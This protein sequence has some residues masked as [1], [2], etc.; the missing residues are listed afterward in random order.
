MFTVFPLKLSS[1]PIHWYHN[2]IRSLSIPSDILQHHNSGQLWERNRWKVRLLLLRY[3]WCTYDI[4]ME[5]FNLKVD[6]PPSLNFISSKKDLNVSKCI[7]INKGVGRLGRGRDTSRVAAG[8]H[9][10]VKSTLS[11][12]FMGVQGLKP[13]EATSFWT[14]LWHKPCFFWVILPEYCQILGV[15]NSCPPLQI[16]GGAPLD[17]P[18]P[19]PMIKKNHWST[20]HFEVA[21]CN[22]GVNSSPSRWHTD[23]CICKLY[24]SLPSGRW[25]A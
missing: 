17:P 10:Y 11:Y 18:V 2:M 20:T 24:C 12:I 21:R 9:Q 4:R 19:T 3:L 8:W 16:L 14:K 5:A 25:R 6:A 23:T 22:M 13:L 15:Q 7:N 1:M